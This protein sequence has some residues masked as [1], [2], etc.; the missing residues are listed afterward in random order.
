MELERN[1][2]GICDLAWSIPMV[3]ANGCRARLTGPRGL[4][5][6]M[7][8][9]KAIDRASKYAESGSPTFP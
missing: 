4:R 8:V 2:K 1:S 5:A 6:A 3:R 7:N 9:A